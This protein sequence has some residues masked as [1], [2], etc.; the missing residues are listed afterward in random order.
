M[1]SRFYFVGTVGIVA[2]LLS[3]CG[4]SSSSADGQE[5]AT[6]SITVGVTSGVHEEILEKV[7]E[8]AAR[9]G[10]E[11]TLE[12]F[13]DF[14]I[15]NTALAEGEIDANSYQN[16]PFLDNY[17]QNN[18][19]SL[20]GLDQTVLNPMGVYSNK[21]ET[22]D[23]LEDGD[24]IGIPSDPTNSARALMLFESSGIITLHEGVG[25]E[26]TSNDIAE[27]PKNIKFIELDSAQIAKQLDDVDASAINTSYAIKNDLNP[28]EDAIFQEKEDSIWANII[29]VRDE[30]K[31]DPV[32]QKLI[33]AY[34]SDEV[35]EFVIEHFEG[36]VLP[37]W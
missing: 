29:V 28:S 6:D 12:V 35:K 7:T 17:N 9:D 23:D 11:I 2:L 22:L 36:S 32:V 18:D 15:P 30:N 27:N 34:H 8:V 26:A 16:T 5:L 25:A 37:T 33:N 31:D 10:L 3:G 14:I 19:D 20:A 24:T 21:I 1:I 4:S 13:S